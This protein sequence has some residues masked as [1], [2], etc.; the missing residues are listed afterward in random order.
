LNSLSEGEKV[1]SPEKYNCFSGVSL[2]NEKIDEI[3]TS[4][5]SG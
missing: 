4:S 5:I 3:F 2:N 1:L